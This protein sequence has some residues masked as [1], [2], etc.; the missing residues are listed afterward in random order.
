MAFASALAVEG[1]GEAVRFV[2]DLLDKVQDW[3]MPLEDDRFVLLAV[4]V[5]DFFFFGDA[6]ERLIDDLERFE[7]FGGGV[8]L[9]DS[10]V[11]QDQTGHRFLFFLN[12]AIAAGDGFAHAGEVVVLARNAAVR[13]FAFAADD[14]FA[15]VA[16]F[17]TAEFPDDHGSD[18]VSSLHVRDVETLDAFG[19]FR[20][21]ERVLQGLADG[22][23]TWLQ[24]AEALFEGMR[25]IV[26]DE[27]EEGAFAAAL[28]SA[29]FDF[30]AGA[31]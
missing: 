25:G 2:A 6:G 17:H 1:D 31:L 12:T 8:Q 22:A 14:E 21:I 24:D 7:G 27:I 20:K 3:R 29:D 26:F 28:R 13:I 11:N 16:F 23:R 4:D 5:K 30:V 18:G 15:V 19:L 9:A 10:A